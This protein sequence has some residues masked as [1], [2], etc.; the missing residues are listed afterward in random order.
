MAQGRS[1]GDHCEGNLEHAQAVEVSLRG[2]DQALL[3]GGIRGALVEILLR[4]GAGR[5]Q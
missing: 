4:D 1:L 5:D 2:S 3:V